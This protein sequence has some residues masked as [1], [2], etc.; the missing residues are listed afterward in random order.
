MW[1]KYT[2][3]KLFALSFIYLLLAVSY[4]VCFLNSVTHSSDGFLSESYV[5]YII[6]I[7]RFYKTSSVFLLYTAAYI[8][9]NVRSNNSH[10]FIRTFVFSFFLLF[11]FL[12]RSFPFFIII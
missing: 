3:S 5:S 1:S 10:F 11:F 6:D 9:G 7:C 12:P 2:M 4:V 8:E